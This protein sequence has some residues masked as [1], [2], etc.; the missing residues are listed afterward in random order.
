MIYT[1]EI[2]DPLLIQFI[3]LFTLYSSDES[4][5]YPDLVTV[6]MDNCNINYID[7]QV[8]LDNL[9]KT[10]HIETHMIGIKTQMFDITEKGK[11]LYDFFMQDVPIYIQDPIRESIKQLF[12]DKRRAHAVQAKVI[13]ISKKEYRIECKLYDDDKLQLLGLNMYAGDRD[14][15]ERMEKKFK[16][17]YVDIYKGIVGVMTHDYGDENED[18]P[19]DMFYDAPPVEKITSADI[20]NDKNNEE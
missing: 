13:P 4:L 12:I 8:A 11:N 10:D 6:I 20:E 7:F 17:H 5:A 15:A 9:K 19:Y 3:I 18:R 14:E 2:D 16:R 1:R